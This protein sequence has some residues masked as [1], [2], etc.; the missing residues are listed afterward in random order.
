MGYFI[1]YRHTGADPERLNKLLPI[2]CNGLKA[3]G[4][5]VY[6]TYFDEIKFKSS[7]HKPHQIMEHAFSKIEE[8]GKLFV[9]I[10]SAKKSE[11]MLVEVGYCIARGIKIIVAK[12]AG[13]NNTYIPSMAQ[14]YFEYDD[15]KDIKTKLTGVKL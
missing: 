15:I 3:R 1:A 9:V 2:I 10:D 6:C 5:K 4:E 7:G 12:R 8:M 11:G 14:V 13:V